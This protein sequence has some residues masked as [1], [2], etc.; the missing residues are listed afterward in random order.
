MARLWMSQTGLFYIR[1]IQ[2]AESYLV[3]AALMSVTFTSSL[4]RQRMIHIDLDGF[5]SHLADPHLNSLSLRASGAIFFLG[6]SWNML[7]VRPCFRHAHG[8]AR[9]G[10][11]QREPEFKME[12]W[13]LDLAQCF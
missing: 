3:L 11:K 7:R 2:Q 12:K 4:S 10:V 6:I 8:A 5:V 13:N 9:I 1:K